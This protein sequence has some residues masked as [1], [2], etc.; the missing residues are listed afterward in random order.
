MEK[1]LNNI[2]LFVDYFYKDFFEETPEI[3]ETFRNTNLSLQ[4]KELKFGL[5]KVFSLIEKR[6]ELDEFLF[7]LGVRHVSYEVTPKH[8][9]IVKRSLM[10]SFRHVLAEEWDEEVGSRVGSLIEH[11]CSKMHDGA[12]TVSKAA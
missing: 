8:Y 12:L 5:K 1:I 2:D 7:E 9:Q 6:E 10:K 11:I 3:V 4:K